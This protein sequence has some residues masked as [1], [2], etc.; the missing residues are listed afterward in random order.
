MKD[1]NRMAIQALLK[2]N[3]AVNNTLAY[4]L[5]Q[6][7]LAYTPKQ[8]LQYIFDFQCQHFWKA[9]IAVWRFE[10]DQWR[11][12]AN[13]Y[14]DDADGRAYGFD[15]LYLFVRIPDSDYHQSTYLGTLA[16]KA[17]SPSLKKY[18]AEAKDLFEKLIE[19]LGVVN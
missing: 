3:L 13:F 15:H 4:Q 16:A 7:Q 5:L 10:V 17:N 19:E 14:Y 8:A 12:S 18:E 11:F 2:S 9:E 1:E 6:S